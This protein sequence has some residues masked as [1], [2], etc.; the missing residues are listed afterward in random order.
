MRTVKKY[1]QKVLALQ[2]GKLHEVTNN[3]LFLVCRLYRYSDRLPL[4]LQISVSKNEHISFVLNT[5][6]MWVVLV[7]IYKLKDD[8]VLLE[9]C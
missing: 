2:C 6:K 7:N 4:S 5:L 1:E 9:S 3:L 8:N